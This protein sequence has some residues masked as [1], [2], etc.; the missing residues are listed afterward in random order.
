[1]KVDQNL[2]LMFSLFRANNATLEC[3]TNFALDSPWKMF[4]DFC[5][6]YIWM[7]A[8]LSKIYIILMIN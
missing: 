2:A 5:Y 7:C 6:D 4:L 8:L 3:D 1:M